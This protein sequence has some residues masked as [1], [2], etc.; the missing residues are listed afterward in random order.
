MGQLASYREAV[1]SAMSSHWVQK[2]VDTTL[3]LF[4]PIHRLAD[5]PMESGTEITG[6]LMLAG[7]LLCVAVYLM[8]GKDF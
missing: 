8:E 2:G 6:T 1:V 7:A 4:P 3:R 5:N